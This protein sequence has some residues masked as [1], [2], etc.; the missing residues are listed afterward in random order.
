[1]RK[2]KLRAAFPHI[3]L[4]KF[5]RLNRFCMCCSAHCLQCAL[6]I[7]NFKPTECVQKALYTEWFQ[8]THLPPQSSTARQSYPASSLGSL[9][10]SF[11]KHCGRAVIHPLQTTGQS[12]VYQT[13]STW[14][15]LAKPAHSGAALQYALLA[16]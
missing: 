4:Q 15:A 1:M 3:A 14:D 9:I 12:F 11:G 6:R 8:H 7:A 5:Y 13:A 2:I 16:E 10:S